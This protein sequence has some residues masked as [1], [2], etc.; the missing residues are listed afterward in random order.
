MNGHPDVECDLW[1]IREWQAKESLRS[2]NVLACNALL[3]EELADEQAGYEL[4]ENYSAGPRL[5]VFGSDDCE[6]WLG[7]LN[8]HWISP[9]AV[10]RLIT[11]LI[12]DLN[13]A[14][15]VGMDGAYVVALDGRSVSDVYH[16]VVR[17]GA[18]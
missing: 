7:C 16:S 17:H 11:L 2:G 14:E 9:E 1:I 15:A 4:P 10:C 6:V 12:G 18:A 3:E 8:G 5:H 13:M